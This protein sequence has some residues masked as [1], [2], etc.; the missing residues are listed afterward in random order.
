MIPDFF[1]GAFIMFLIYHIMMVIFF[2]Y[3]DDYLYINI[4]PPVVGWAL[5]LLIYAIIYFGRLAT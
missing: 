1:L 5:T 2:Q 4:I 3:I